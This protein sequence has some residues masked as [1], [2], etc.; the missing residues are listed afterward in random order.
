MEVPHMNQASSAPGTKRAAGSRIGVAA[1]TTAV[2]GTSISSLFYMLSYRTGLSPLWT[3][4]LRLFFTLILMAPVTFLN[5]NLREKL[6]HIPKKWF[7]YSAL[8]GT[9]LACHFTT[10]ALALAQ[11]DVFAAGAISGISLL[12][13]ALLSS[14]FLRER[15]SR[16]ALVGMI[17]ATA[18]VV[19]CNLGGT[20]GTLSG[21]LYSLLAAALF[22][23][24]TMLG[25]KIRMVLDVNTYTSVVYFF[26]FVWLA[27]F[28]LVF[29]APPAGFRPV[30]L[31]W[32]LGLAVFPTLLGHT[33]QSVSLK[34]FKAPTVS[35]VLLTNMVTAPLVVFFVLGDAPTK[36]TFIGG[37]VIIVGVVWYLWMELREARATALPAGV[38]R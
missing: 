36:Y 13:T 27:V 8:T 11:T 5:R 1:L 38:N 37:S 33:M 29:S 9:V 34:Y 7:W 24:Y 16:A 6:L 14:L 19:V 4:A 25:R 26:T 28:A 23:L 12:I 35:A 31:L 17:I 18:G 15:T 10:W 22:A 2:V 20:M 30:G 32:T 21:N 3:N